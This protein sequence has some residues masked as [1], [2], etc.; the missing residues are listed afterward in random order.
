MSKNVVIY[1]RDYKKGTGG[2]ASIVELSNSLRMIGYNV[3]FIST[4]F[5]LLTI[6]DFFK[7]Q[8]N[9]INVGGIFDNLIFNKFSI[10]KNNLK[11]LIKILLSTLYTIFNYKYFKNYFKTIKNSDLIIFTLPLSFEDISKIR[12]LSHK[13]KFLYNHAGSVYAFQNYWLKDVVDFKSK[14][15]KSKYELFFNQFDFMLFQSYDQSLECSNK[16][17]NLS[18]KIIHLNPTSNENDII[19]AKDLNN[20]YSSNKKIILNVGTIC[21]RKNQLLTIECFIALRTLSKNIELH[22]VG[23]NK[24]DLKYYNLLKLTVNNHNLNN[25]VFFHGLKKDYLRY[26]NFSDL[27]ILSSKAEGMPRILREAMFM[28]IPIIASRIL[29]NI[30]LISNG[31]GILIDD[32]NPDLYATAIKKIL[33]NKNYSNKMVESAFNNYLNKYSNKI[34]NTNLNKLILKIN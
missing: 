5:S 3:K 13:S 33:N 23:D 20:P 24:S 12:K 25:K 28:R 30:E 10:K 31:N 11:I 19:N 21:E 2:F 34:Y 9:L 1:L 32:E 8:N 26:M 27:I 16:F 22:F 6:R 29:G 4:S 14:I 18:S 7:P 17:P 15:N